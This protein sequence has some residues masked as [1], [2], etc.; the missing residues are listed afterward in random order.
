VVFRTNAAH[1]PQEIRTR[2]AA[3]GS[4]RNPHTD[5]AHGRFAARAGLANLPRWPLD[6]TPV[7]HLDAFRAHVYIHTQIFMHA[8]GWGGGG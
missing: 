7:K 3:H 8:V 6:D 4:A 2:D 1:G 5:A